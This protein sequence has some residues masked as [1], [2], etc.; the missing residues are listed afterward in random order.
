MEVMS[1]VCFRSIGPVAS[2]VRETYTFYCCPKLVRRKLPVM[3]KSLRTVAA[4]LFLLPGTV[5]TAV[6][7]MSA[8]EQA[9]G[10]EKTPAVKQAVKFMRLHSDDRGKPLAMQTA[11]VSYIPAEGDPHRLRV[12]LVAAVHVGEE[13]YFED[14]NELFADYDAV[15]YE[16][17]APEDVRPKAGQQ[18]RSGSPIGFLQGGM[19]S[20][21]ELKFQLEEIDYQRANFVHADLSP[22]QFKKTMDR[23][24][25]S[26]LQMFFH[27]IG[28]SMVLQSKDPDRTV[29]AE[30][31]LALFSD[32]KA[33]RLRR[34]LAQQ[35][36]QMDGITLFGGAQGS[37][38]ITERNGRALEVLARQ[39]ESGRRKVAIFYG[40]AHMLDFHRRLIKDF[41]LK[42][43][44][45]RWLDAWD[46]AAPK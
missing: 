21:L 33:L 28:Q 2:V 27:M 41:G 14:L 36:D 18:N 34:I 32:D 25:E 37:T 44:D 30:L 26:P 10:I 43:T 23:R 12:D 24:G 5:L 38:I 39:I 8:E 11:V 3:S 9:A 45:E 1:T 35:M 22:E 7:T 46:L 15:L 19:T 13:S 20:L 42:K 4:V 31:L 29:D 40:A 6:D 16:L 17:V